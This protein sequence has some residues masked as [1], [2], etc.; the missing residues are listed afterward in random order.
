MKKK[1]NFENISKKKKP[2]LTSKRLNN[3]YEVHQKF[4]LVKCTSKTAC[5]ICKYKWCEEIFEK[6]GVCMENGDKTNE[7]WIRIL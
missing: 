5:V 6:W 3:P 2:V 1:G 4:Q 7:P